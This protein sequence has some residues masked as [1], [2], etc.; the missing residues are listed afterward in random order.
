MGSNARSSPQELEHLL[1]LAKPKLIIT[2]REALPTILNVS[3][4]KGMLSNQVCL[5]DESAT[6]DI[7]QLLGVGSTS[8]FSESGDESYLN[9]S[10]LLSYGENDWVSFN[11]EA[12]AK[13]TPAAMFSTSGTGGLPKAAVLSHHAIVSQHTTIQYDVPFQVRRLMSLPM[14]HLFGALWTH[15]F[16]VRYGQPLYVLPRFEINQF[17]TAVYQYQVTETYMVPAMIHSFNRC[18]LPVVDYLASLRYVGVAGAPIDGASMQQFRELLHHD[19]YASQLWGMTEVG[20]VFQ[21]RYGERGNAGSIGSLQPGYEIRLVGADGNLIFEDNKPGELY[22]RGSGLLTCY[23][24]RDD[25]KDSQG[26]FRTGDVAYVNNGLYF[27]VGRTKELI[28]VRGYVFL[29]FLKISPAGSHT[30]AKQM[31]SRP[32]GTRIR[33]PQT[34][35]Y[36]RRRGNR[37]PSQRWQHRSPPRLR[38]ALKDPLRNPPHIRGTLPLLPQP[39]RLIQGPGRRDRLCRGNPAHS[40]WQDPAVQAH[41]DEQLSRDCL[42]LACAVP[43]GRAAVCGDYAWRGNRCLV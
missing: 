37:G 36:R 1:T 30:K 5:L 31:A 6:G 33:H 7:A 29:M 39:A 25:A 22:V 43:A 32:R 10:Q 3:A 16:P 41:T 26:W 34:P 24:G 8:Y 28:K 20:V 15:I 23:R 35:R 11:D 13:S 12:I 14:F 38:R 9:F 2:T 42:F 18:N 4:S 17:V 27:I 40:K 19:A 21:N